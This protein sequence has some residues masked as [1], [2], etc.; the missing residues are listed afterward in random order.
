MKTELTLSLRQARRALCTTAALCLALALAILPG[1]IVEAQAVANA[2]IHGVVVDS[3]GLVV[4]NA[5][6]VATQTD[7]GFAATGKSDD[8]GL[9][10]LP[11]LPVGP[12]K[13]TFS[14]PGFSGLQRSGILLQVGND[15]DIG[16]VLKVGS[17]SESVTVTEGAAQV[18]TE[19][20]AI[21][22]VVDQRRIVDLPL[23]GRNAAD[24]VLLS[25]A[26][27]PT[28]NGDMT[29]NKTYG[30][31][32]TSAIGGSL[33]I[34]VAGGQGNQI[35]YL[36]DGG[37]HND[38][39]SNV[40]MPFPFP[41]VLQEFSVQTTGLEAQYGVHPSATVNII[42]KSG[43]NQ[44]HGGIFEFLRNSYA[45]ANNRINGYTDLKR[46]QFG[47]Y[48][49]GPILHN[50]LFFFGG[51]QHTA[52][53]IA[54]ATTSSYVPTADMLAGNFTPYLQYEQSLSATNKCPTLL[55]SAGFVENTSTCSATINTDLYLDGTHP[56][57]FGSDKISAFC[58]DPEVNFIYAHSSGHAPLDD[59]QKLATALK[60]KILVPIHTEDAEGFRGNFENVVT[61]KDGHV[62]DLA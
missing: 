31:T 7:S 55:A 20:T 56:E 3:Q 25:G 21:S 24:L 40:N 54:P 8:A 62:F 13:V 19:D 17:V 49:G 45:N 47:G 33:N 53:R 52:L 27:A 59:L 16:A 12:Y 38:S 11:N 57:Y 61:L 36:L 14:A 28:T 29:T 2:K 18:Q 9:Y 39:F 32:G 60:P 10:T 58:S 6:I 50:K 37:D 22:T 43:S 51:Y 44:W 15:A 5:V 34:A 23:N 41:D 26:S 48:F 46:N 30:S 42:T 1:R 4:P 35:N